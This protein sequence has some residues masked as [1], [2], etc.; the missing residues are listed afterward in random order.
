MTPTRTREGS[1][2]PR[3]FLDSTRTGTVVTA[4][5]GRGFAR[6]YVK[7]SGEASLALSPEEAEAVE[8]AMAAD[9]TGRRLPAG[10]PASAGRSRR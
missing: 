4:I 9:A 10:G 8:Q 3:S 1:S 5:R 7:L 6:V 2:P